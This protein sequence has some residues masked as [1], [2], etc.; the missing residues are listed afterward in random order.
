MREL[1]LLTLTKISYFRD[2]VDDNLLAR[3]QEAI[4]LV[5]TLKLKGPV[6]AGCGAKYRTV[7]RECPQEE[8]TSMPLLR[9]PFERM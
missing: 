5:G 1:Y 3:S 9:M 2:L 6:S 7:L 8:S 4:C